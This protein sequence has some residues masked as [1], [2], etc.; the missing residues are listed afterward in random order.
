MDNMTVLIVELVMCHLVGDYVLQSD[1]LAKTKGTEWYN[2]LVHC[3]LYCVPF[4]V[5]FGI[6]WRLAV[7]LIT[8]IIIDAAKARYHVINLF[9]DQVFHYCILLIYTL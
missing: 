6:D 3:I 1:Y 5:V 7:I 8:H 9:T 2:L 4:A